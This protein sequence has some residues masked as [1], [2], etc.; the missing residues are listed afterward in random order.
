MQKKESTCISALSLCCPVNE[1]VS[2]L[3]YFV[4]AVSDEARKEVLDTK[5]ARRGTLR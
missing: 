2:L 5:L 1:E 4:G 3:G